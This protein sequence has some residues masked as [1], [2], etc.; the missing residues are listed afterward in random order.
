MLVEPILTTPTAPA[1]P[2]HAPRSDVASEAPPAGII[3]HDPARGVSVFRLPNGNE[4]TLGGSSGG[5]RGLWSRAA[6]SDP[7]VEPAA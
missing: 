7:D 1:P 5:S 2:R 3:G 6:E 4:I